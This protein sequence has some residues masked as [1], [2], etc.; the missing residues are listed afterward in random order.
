M[1]FHRVALCPQMGISRRTA[2]RTDRNSYEFLRKRE[3]YGYQYRSFGASRSRRRRGF[4]Y[5]ELGYFRCR[6]HFKAPSKKFESSIALVERPDMSHARVSQIF[7]SNNPDLKTIAKI[8]YA[9][10]EDFEIIREEDLKELPRKKNLGDYRPYVVV[11]DSS[12][13][14]DN[15]RSCDTRLAA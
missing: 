15:S 14:R 7:F 3:K 9:L 10:A 6:L 12:I 8:A 2:R 13:W 4:H 1:T 5:R 11:A